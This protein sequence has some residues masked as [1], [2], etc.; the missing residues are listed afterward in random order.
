MSTEESRIAKMAS[1]TAAQIH[2]LFVVTSEQS[3]Q[4]ALGI[5]S[6]I[7]SKGGDCT[8]LGVVSDLIE[9]QLGSRFEWRRDSDK[10]ASAK[11][12]EDTVASYKAYLKL[13]RRTT[14]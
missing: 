7:E 6:L 4:E 3:L 5:L 9:K 12:R 11:G 13:G 10:L 8:N 1:R 2:N 14:W